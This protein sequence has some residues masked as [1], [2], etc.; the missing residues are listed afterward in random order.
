[1]LPSSVASLKV[2]AVAV[3]DV[4]PVWNCTSDTF[5][6]R[7][8]I[9]KPASPLS[10]NVLALVRSCTITSRVSTSFLLF[11]IVIKI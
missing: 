4:S 8:L 2:V 11:S 5:C 1:M 10:S 9:L 7:L 6:L 3:I